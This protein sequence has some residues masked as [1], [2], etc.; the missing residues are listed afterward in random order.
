MRVAKSWC[1]WP[2]L[3]ACASQAAPPHKTAPADSSRVAELIRRL[4][5]DA[6]KVRDEATKQLLQREEAEPAAAGA[7]FDQ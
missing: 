2:F 1:S 7:Y 4:G 3:L 5:N 6:Y